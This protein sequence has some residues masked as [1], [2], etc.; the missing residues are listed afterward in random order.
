MKTEVQVTQNNF[1]YNQLLIAS[2]LPLFV[3]IF[4]GPLSDRYG[5][6]P[7]MLAVLAGFAALAFVYLVEALQPTWPVWV[8]YLGTAVVNFTGSW[9][10]FNMAV[11]SY[12]ADIT[13]PDSRTRR[14]A[15]VDACWYMGGPLGRLL[16]GWVYHIGGSAPVFLISLILW[17]LC[18]IVLHSSSKYLGFPVLKV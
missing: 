1:N 14:L 13:T 4:V 2:L 10:V 7:P 5:R 6:K 9:V 12:V 8:L 15:L 18:F 11:Y 16:G 3:V 17:M